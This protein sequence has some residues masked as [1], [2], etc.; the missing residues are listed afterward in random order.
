MQNVEFIQSVADS[1]GSQFSK[2]GQRREFYTLREV[3]ELLN[4]RPKPFSRVAEEKYGLK[5]IYIGSELNFRAD[6]VDNLIEELKGD[7]FASFRKSK[8]A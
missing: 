6:Q 1:V 5:K 4:K 2:V 8:A 7:S 3:A